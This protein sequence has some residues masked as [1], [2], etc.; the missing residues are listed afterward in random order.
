MHKN[1]RPKKKTD[2]TTEFK[3]FPALNQQDGNSIQ[4]PAL[5]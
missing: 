3:A 1:K 5:S 2:R 4:L